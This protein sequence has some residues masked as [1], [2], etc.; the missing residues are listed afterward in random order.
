M[1]LSSH[2]S[3][4]TH[5]NGEDAASSPSASLN[6][7]MDSTSTSLRRLVVI[8]TS[9]LLAVSLIVVFVADSMYEHAEGGPVSQ[10]QKSS[11]EIL[12]LE[13]KL[14]LQTDKLNQVV[15]NY[16]SIKAQEKKLQVEEAK[17]RTEASSIRSLVHE[18]RNSAI[19]TKYEIHNLKAADFSKAMFESHRKEKARKN[20][21]KKARM[22]APV[23]EAPHPP[24]PAAR[25]PTAAQAV[26]GKAP[27]TPLVKAQVVA[28]PMPVYAAKPL[29]E[30]APK[31]VSRPALPPRAVSPVYVRSVPEHA[32]RAQVAQQQL[33][34][35]RQ[36]RAAA[37]MFPQYEMNGENSIWKPL[38]MPVVITNQPSD[39]YRPPQSL[40]QATDSAEQNA[41]RAQQLA[42]LRSPQYERRMKETQRRQMEATNS[43]FPLL[44]RLRPLGP[45]AADP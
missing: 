12:S 21:A 32:I 2:V 6:Q 17:L 3:K 22:H 18:A 4:E 42:F 43:P 20:I 36:V 24:P 25:H 37:V 31:V 16:D 13:S 9:A 40:D 5:G 33:P 39:A 35:A 41:V 23:N 27:V 45:E 15:K 11:T 28:P 1:S 19:K 44:P 10:L 14:K 38:R 30:Q 7:G 8:S 29:I 26:H 34:I